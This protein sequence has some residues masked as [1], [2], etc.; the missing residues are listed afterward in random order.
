MPP[1]SAAR[2]LDQFYTDRAVAA[3]LTARLLAYLA[4]SG[5]SPEHLTFLEPSA[6]A[7][8]F[9]RALSEQCP[10][11]ALDAVD[12]D[13]RYPGVR[14]GDFLRADPQAQ[15]VF[16]NP[17][18]GKNAGLAV[19]F[20]NHAA[21]SAQVIAFIVPRT[22]EKHSLQKRLDPGFAC[23]LEVP[24][25]PNSFHFEGEPVAVPCV[26]QV[27]ERLPAGQRRDVASKPVTH[28]DFTFQR[29]PEGAAF[30][31]QR[32][33][34]QAG[35][36]KGLDATHL[37]PPSHYFLVPRT[38]LPGPELRRRLDSLDWSQIK[39]RTAGNP[40]ISKAELVE[41]YRAAEFA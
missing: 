33:G 32:V 25:D 18:F 12:I 5:R 10:T 17:P 26:F 38:G 11:A 4:E 14:L 7:G 39:A 2:L 22:F 27:W 6:G 16:G 41:A 37:A 9:V 20:F 1:K 15:V 30:A 34:V 31:F 40:S 13:P 28:P 19:R 3:T 36:T 29:V 23:T 35:R 8:A 21:L 24:V